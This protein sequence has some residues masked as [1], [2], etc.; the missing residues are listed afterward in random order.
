MEDDECVTDS[1]FHITYDECESAL[2]HILAAPK[3]DALIDHVCFRP[4]V[5]ARTFP[6]Y[7]E[8]T[9]ERGI[10]GERWRTQPWLRLPDGA[11]DPRIQ[12][13]ILSK[14]V[15]DLC[16]RNRDRAAHPGDPII[17]DMD[18]GLEN[19]PTGSRLQAGT[20]VLEVSDVFNT[21]CVKWRDRYGGDSLRWINEPRYRPLR[22][23]GILCSIVGDG[24]VSK[25]DRLTKVVIS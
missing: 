21:G 25:G 16:W 17:A 6:D 19:L 5:G 2:E 24:R 14:R 10:V 20:A 11:P 22:L 3:D 23:R 12:V 13:S 18:L 8:L 15:M 1:G 9:V 7:L 4:T